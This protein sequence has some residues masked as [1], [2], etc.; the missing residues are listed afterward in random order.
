MECEDSQVIQCGLCRSPLVVGARLG[1]CQLGTCCPLCA[2]LLR[3]CCTHYSLLTA[4]CSTQSTAVPSTLSPLSNPM[5]PQLHPDLT[6]LHHWLH[7]TLKKHKLAS[8]TSV[9]LRDALAIA[10][11][12]KPAALL[13]FHLPPSVLELTLQRILTTDAQ[14][15][16]PLVL[17][18]LTHH[19]GT[20]AVFM[21]HRPSFLSNSPLHASTA[22][23]VDV[24]PSLHEPQLLKSVAAALVSDQLHSFSSSLSTA[25][26]TNVSVSHL[27]L[28]SPSAVCMPT[29]CGWLLSYP[30]LYTFPSSPTV[31]PTNC[32]SN[33]PLVL[34][35]VQLHPTAHLTS[36]SASFAGQSGCVPLQSFSVPTALLPE[37][38][39]VSAIHAWEKRMSEVCRNE[40]VRQWVS[41]LSTSKTAVCL[42]RVSL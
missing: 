25:L 33:Q 21:L 39:V 12:V 31:P 8:F 42:P 29:L 16:A 34:F 27:T 15:F 22:Q 26:D 38:V 11:G 5:Q 40:S 32:L 2:A 6:A 41:A 4:H 13:D 10:L 7:R 20:S 28:P 37:P 36:L 3:C 9:L 30:L 23:L 24:S 1:W 14:L 18:T 19:A 35:T 17:V